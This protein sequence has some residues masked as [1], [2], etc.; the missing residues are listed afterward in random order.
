MPATAMA[1]FGL[2]QAS[3]AIGTG[4]GLL[5]EGHNDRRQLK[6]Q[7]KLQNL[8]MAGQKNMAEYNY[9]LEMRKWKDTG[10]EAQMKQLEEAG[11]N[12]GLVYGMGGAG[13]QSSQTQGG[14]VTGGHAPTGGGEVIA[15]QGMAL[16]RDMQ[17]AQIENLK[18]NTDATRAGIPKIGEETEGIRLDNYFKDITMQRRVQEVGIR[19]RTEIEE[20]HIAEADNYIKQDTML[21]EIETIANNALKS[22]FES[23]GAD[24]DN[25]TK[26]LEQDKIKKQIDEITQKITE[27]K[28]TIKQK[29]A[30]LNIQ[31]KERQLRVWEAEIKASFPG[32]G[33]VIGK[34]FN[35]V[36]QGFKNLMGKGS[37]K[38]TD[39]RTYDAPT[40]LKQ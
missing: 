17:A 24:I 2:Q 18:A 13:G 5:L 4:M 10:Y 11:L 19:V 8:E 38:E 35:D 29:W 21:D 31:E 32:A 7:E 26:K 6:Q 39:R 33:Q 15:E 40:N 14:K 22:G 23:T 37:K 20:L 30:G 9:G 34:V 3:N 25:E 36:I 16:Q 1:Q 12:P 28:A 27:S